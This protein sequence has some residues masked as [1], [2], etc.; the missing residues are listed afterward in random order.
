M[1]KII[2]VRF[3]KAG[4]VHYFDPGDLEV[5]LLDLVM[6][7]TEYGL[8]AGSVVI[9]AGQ[10]L[11]SEINGLP[12]SVLRRAT[13]EDLSKYGRQADSGKDRPTLG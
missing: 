1:S 4:K 2:G 11:Y 6:I 10:V 13:E 5:G 9:E 3:Q 12:K 8:E 7:E